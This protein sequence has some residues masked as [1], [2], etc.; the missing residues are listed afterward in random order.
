M[1]ALGVLPDL[2]WLVPAEMY[3][4]M[5]NVKVND[6][7]LLSNQLHSAPRGEKWSKPMRAPEH[8]GLATSA[9]GIVTGIAL[10]LNQLHGEGGRS[11][12]NLSPSFWVSSENRQ[13]EERDNLQEKA[14]Q[15]CL[16]RTLSRRWKAVVVSLGEMAVRHRGKQWDF[17]PH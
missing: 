7:R 3:A 12:L 6:F 10:V 4:W 9:L 16:S 15:G 2:S 5:P 13:R 14:S 11:W 17:F 1:T 8:P